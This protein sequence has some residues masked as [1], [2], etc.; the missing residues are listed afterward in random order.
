MSRIPLDHDQTLRQL[1]ELLDRRRTGPARALAE[2]ALLEFP[3]SPALLQT[4]AWIDWM[5]DRLDEAEAT[6]DRILELD[7]ES[8][9]A[10]YLLSRIYT[11]T[12]RLAEAELILIDLLRANPESA[13]LY[14]DYASL[15]LETFHLVKA[16][17]LAAEALRLEPQDE[18][19]LHVAVMT[20]FVNTPG[21]ET[22]RRLQRL[23]EEHPDQFG[24]AVR[25][26]QVL[27]DKGRNAEAYELARRLVQQQPD[28]E[29]LVELAN[30]LRHA[31]HWSMKP[32]WPMQKFGW[33]GSI[34]LYVLIVAVIG[35]G[36]LEGTALE[37][38]VQP[39]GLA[40]L[41]YVV[42]SWTWPPLLRRILR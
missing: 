27:S 41:L 39:L 34:G 22:E 9:D 7:P 21:P 16:E 25:L 3:D 31:A 19:A 23:L 28:N 24:S 42:Y 4:S 26:V 8:F 13:R 38:L 37:S 1:E 30:D 12:D 11:E 5:E 35:S 40:F 6:V 10:R 18:S 15:M 33:A 17:R 20:A 14:A 2:Q 29:H 32:M 36:V